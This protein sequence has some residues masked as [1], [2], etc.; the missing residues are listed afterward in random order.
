VAIRILNLRISNLWTEFSPSLI[1]GGFLALALL[2][3]LHYFSNAN[4]WYKLIG[5]ILVGGMAYFLGLWI[6]AK[7]VLLEGIDLVR[8]IIQKEK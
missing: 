6:F 2:A 5:G 7:Q 4:D 1:G 3:F 8:A